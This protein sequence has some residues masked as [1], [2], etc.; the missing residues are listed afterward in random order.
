MGCE[1]TTEA[2]PNAMGAVI[3]A[4]GDTVMV[5]VRMRPFNKKEIEEKRG[6][7]ITLDYAARTVPPPPLLLL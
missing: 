4:K 6:P 5:T 2:D 7:C 3:E 1:V